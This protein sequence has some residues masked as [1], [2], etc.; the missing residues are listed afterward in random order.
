MSD[1]LMKV[2]NTCGVEK[3]LIHFGVSGLGTSYERVKGKCASCVG[4]TH[5]ST[6]LGRI[7]TLCYQYG[8]TDL[9]YMQMEFNQD[10]RCAICKDNKPLEI[11]HNHITGKVRGLLCT[12]CNTMLGM[13]EDSIE[14]LQEAIKYLE[15]NE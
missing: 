3:A 13:S 2:C 10:K 4:K 7:R 15:K 11:D 8:I 5:Y 12:K 9:D 1:L 6:Y 14:R